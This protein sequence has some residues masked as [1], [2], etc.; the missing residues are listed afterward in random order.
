MVNIVVQSRPEGECMKI[1][2]VREMYVAVSGVP[3]ANPRHGEVMAL[4][5]LDMIAAVS[6]MKTANGNA[7][8]RVKVGIH[9]GGVTGGVIGL[10]V[11]MM[12]DVLFTI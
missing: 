6:K 10:A 5:G 11:C 8:I 7:T 3:T 2:N 12:Y 1:E 4:L 9:S